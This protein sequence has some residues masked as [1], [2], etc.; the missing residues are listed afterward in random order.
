MSFSGWQSLLTIINIK[1]DKQK[2]KKKM[3]SMCLL[4]FATKAWAYDLD[5]AHQIQYPKVH[6][7][8]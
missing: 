3:T 1:N 7:R 4:I 8:W 2:K 5:I 6:I